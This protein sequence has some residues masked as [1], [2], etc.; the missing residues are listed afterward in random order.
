MS[1]KPGTVTIHPPP[2]AQEEGVPVEVPLEKAVAGVPRFPRTSLT[3]DVDAGKLFWEMLQ[4]V[5][6]TTC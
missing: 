5:W 2:Y 6:G 3:A 1:S 4:S